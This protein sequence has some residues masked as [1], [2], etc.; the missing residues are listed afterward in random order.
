MRESCLKSRASAAIERYS[1]C[2]RLKI[3]TPEL[4]TVRCDKP[5]K[6]NSSENLS[7]RV[8]HKLSLVHPSFL[9]LKSI[10]LSVFIREM[11]TLN[12]K[13]LEGFSLTTAMD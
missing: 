10:C 8:P 6:G 4:G 9:H 13:P 1:L 7:I 3:M 5:I 2:K 11:S 12:D